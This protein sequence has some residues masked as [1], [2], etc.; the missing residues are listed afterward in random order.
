MLPLEPG[1]RVL[2]SIGN[3]QGLRALLAFSDLHEN[4]LSRRRAS[5]SNEQDLLQTERFVLHEVLQLTCARA[6]ALTQADS[7]LVA[8]CEGGEFVCRASAGVYGIPQG[9]H[10]SR[11]SGLLRD[12]LA[13]GKILRCDD[14]ETDIRAQFDVARQLS[15]RSCVIVP[16]LGRSDRLGVLQAFATAPWSFTDTDIR[17]LDLFAELVLAALKPADQD[18]RL[19]WLSDVAGELLH[20]KHAVVETAADEPVVTEQLPALG[21]ECEPAIAGPAIAEPTIV[22]HLIAEPLI[23]EPLITEP[24]ITEPAIAAIPV[25]ENPAAA[26][27]Q[28]AATAVERSPA[29]PVEPEAALLP[30]VEV[31]HREFREAELPEG[32]LGD[33]NPGDIEEALAEI[34]ERAPATQESTTPAA[35]LGRQESAAATVPDLGELTAPIVIPVDI[36]ETQTSERQ[37]SEP[38]AS[39]RQIPE[40]DDD[41]PPTYLTFPIPEPVEPL[42]EE[43][44][45][46]PKSWLHGIFL[47]VTSSPGMS[48]V[49]TLMVV[50]GLFSAGVW[51]GMQERGSVAPARTAAGPRN[52]TSPGAPNVTTPAG[53]PSVT[54]AAA[55][56]LPNEGL[57]DGDEAPRTPVSEEQ[58]GKLPKITGVRHWSSAMGSTVV[59]DMEDQV[60]YEVHRLMSPERI[61][62]DL[63]G[64]ALPQDLEGKT[65]DVGDPSLTRVRVAQPVAGLT[66]VVLDTKDGSNFSVSMETNPYRLVVELREGPKLV[67]ASRVAPAAK[68]AMAAPLATTAK[69]AAPLP[70]VH[71]GKFRIVLDAGH[72]GWDLGTVGRQ[73]LLEK[74]LVLDVTKRL[75]KLL[76]SR[77]GAE[78]LFTRSGDDYLALDERADIANQAQAD[79]FVSVHA[80]YSNSAAA[81]GVETYYTNLFSAP[82]L[83]E[84]EKNADGTLTRAT[85]VTL[86]A[87]ALHDKIEESRRLAASVQHALYSTLAAK[88]PDIRDR[89]T[90]D[91]SFVVL[92]GTT[93]P[94]ILTEISFVSSPADERNLQSE[95]YREQIAEAIYKGISHYEE[96]VPKT[97]VA[98]LRPVAT[99]R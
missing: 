72:G 44:E 8:L 74:D 86:S 3:Q 64:T 47:P 36:F 75:G 77:S 11:E 40:A 35:P 45:R 91:A 31:A 7:V 2:A 66:R 9:I 21:T 95:A 20:P 71:A 79:L 84:I 51:W 46:V 96:S 52:V 68:P 57:A 23:A 6:L 73:G 60:N 80:N 22:E 85:P 97:R 17:C 34:V 1:V 49:L 24:L 27:E 10:L 4:I 43:Q 16:L 53:L 13:S 39:E 88:N 48:V 14:T 89:G 87:E 29:T 78:V 81:R 56:D 50:A 70:V 26:I 25:E 5:L 94:A 99:G 67:A 58:L 61:Y 82:G 32:S 69:S 33:T 15:A 92:T 18:R 37:I 38:R 41:V 12:C 63:R 59:I 98:Q 30:T 28:N 90:K 19:H 93:M 83:K 65:M 76:E 62:F 55:Q 42:P 54:P